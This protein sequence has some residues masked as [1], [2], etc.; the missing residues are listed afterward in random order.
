MTDSLREIQM[1]AAGF[2]VQASRARDAHQAQAH[3]ARRGQIPPQCQD[4]LFVLDPQGQI[5]ADHP[6]VAE[7]RGLSPACHDFVAPTLGQRRGVVGRPHPSGGRL[8]PPHHRPGGGR[9]GL[10]RETT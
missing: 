3:L 5:W 1:V 8:R 10:P 9:T 7:A 4:G 6:S 2:P